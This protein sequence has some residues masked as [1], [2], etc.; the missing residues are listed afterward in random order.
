MGRRPSAPSEA[1][2]SGD[3]SEI[4]K[5]KEPYL[6]INNIRQYVSSWRSKGYIGTPARHLLARWRDCAENREGEEQ[7][8]FCQREAVETLM[9]LLRSSP[10]PEQHEILR[11]LQE[12]NAEWNDGINRM[13]VKMATGSGKTY[14][15]AMLAAC[16]ESLHPTGC[17]IVVIVPNLTV[18]DRLQDLKDKHHSRDLF[19]GQRTS[20]RSAQLIVENFH[21]FRC[22]DKTFEG[23]GKTSS[24]NEKKFLKPETINEKPEAMLDRLIGVD[25]EHLPLYIFQDEGHHCRRS[26]EHTRKERDEDLDSE[27]QWF[28]ALQYFKEYR[29]LHAVIDFSATPAYLTQP[30]NLPYPIFPW[31]ISDFGVEEAIESG[32]CKIPRLPRPLRHVED[33]SRYENIYEYCVDVRGQESVWRQEPPIEITE[34]VRILAKDWEET[35]FRPYKRANRV[36]AVIVVVNRV[37]NAILLYQWLSGK[38]KGHAWEPGAIDSFSNVDPITNAPYPVERLPSLLVTSNIGGEE[39]DTAE[40]ESVIKE[41]MS[42][43]APEKSKEEAKEVIRET[44][45]SVGKQG[46]LGQGIRCVVSVA[47]LSEGWDAK[48]VTHVLGFRRFN[49]K[50]LCEQVVGR[51]LRRPSLDTPT[52]AEYAEIFGVPYPG[53][54]S[55]FD[56]DSE[57]TPPTPEYEVYAVSEQSQHKI[58]WPDI[59]RIG[60]QI[61]VGKRFFLDHSRVQPWKP[62]LPNAVLVRLKALQGLGKEHVIQADQKRDQQVLYEL[63]SGLADRWWSEQTPGTDLTDEQYLRRGSLFIDAKCAIQDWLEHPNVSVKRPDLIS[64]TYVKQIVIDDVAAACVSEEGKP[65]VV[66]PIF[67]NEHAHCKSTD[68]TRFMTTLKH[69][70]SDLKKSHLNTAA[71]HSSWETEVATLIDSHDQVNS[72]VRNFRLNWR[73]PW[74]DRQLGYWREYEPDFVVRL[75]TNESKR[76]HCVVVEVKGKEKESSNLKAEAAER[77]CHALS[78]SDDPRIPE[79]WS[80]LYLDEPKAFYEEI[81]QHIKEHIDG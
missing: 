57:P 63:A 81:D 49:S 59:A 6:S 27:G 72:W 5:E 68:G 36:P 9:W 67:K 35:R 50:L 4:A 7:P 77:W 62:N 22:G 48:T 75:K 69:K 20:S 64:D 40:L 34:L 25:S 23:L 54:K 1:H 55:D 39:K 29:N 15:M 13:A 60:V 16:L 17:Q 53:L 37:K 65:A 52:E 76:I 80:Y 70:V 58:S 44:F 31:C 30:K 28:T 46:E 41:Q 66:R 26:S 43:R 2:V 74:W 42:L 47:M 3:A 78:S 12:V 19:G 32:I 8:Y 51:A 73:I 11:C 71:C 18:R 14:T 38:K 79:N 24:Q 21:K 56:T 61:A 10:D 45:Q 33:R